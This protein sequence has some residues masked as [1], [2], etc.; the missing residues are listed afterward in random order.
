MSS[1]RAPRSGTDSPLLVGPVGRAGSPLRPGGAGFKIIFP[2][3]W[4]VAPFPGW[5][6]GVV[7]GLQRRGAVRHGS[8]EFAERDTDAVVLLPDIGCS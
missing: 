5:P 8:D 7:G 1:H 2:G 6:C 4:S 3:S